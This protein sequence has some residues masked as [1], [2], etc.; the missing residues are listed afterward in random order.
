M[1][2]ATYNLRFGGKLG[3]RVHWQKILEEINP[4]V[5]LVQETHSPEHYVSEEITSILKPQ[6]SWNAVDGRPWGSAVYVSKGQVTPLETLSSKFF[7]WV[8][9]VKVEGFGWPISEGQSL[10]VYS[11]HAPSIGSSYQKQVNLILDGIE[12]QL[13]ADAAVIIGGDFNLALG[14]RHPSEELQQDQPK[15][16]RRFRREFGLMNCWQMANPNRNLPQ[17]L[18]WSNGQKSCLSTATVFLCPL[19]SIAIWKVQR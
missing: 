1:R 18:R 9:G 13:P 6:I 17:T 4:D 8:V 14:F 7:G 11:I 10:Y 2:I 15:L 5:F 3:N 16:M 19:S 12:A